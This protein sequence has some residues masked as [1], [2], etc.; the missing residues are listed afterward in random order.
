MIGVQRVGMGWSPHLWCAP[1]AQILD[2]YRKVLH[3]PRHHRCTY[4]PL[5]VSGGIHYRQDP[6][7][8][9]YSPVYVILIALLHDAIHKSLLLCRCYFLSGY[10][11]SHKI[12]RTVAIE[13]GCQNMVVATSII[14]LSFTDPEVTL[15][16]LTHH[17]KMRSLSFRLSF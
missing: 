5:R 8:C 15:L 14:L 3:L 1:H 9:K 6:L 17:T 13:T 4:T 7:F 2:Y 12:C 16:H 10:R 11:Q